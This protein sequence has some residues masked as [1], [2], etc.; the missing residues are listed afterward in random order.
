MSVLE[1]NKKYLA[2]R[3]KTAQA[4]YKK[5]LHEDCVNYIEFTAA[6]AWLNFSGFYKLHSLEKILI[7]IGK[8]LEPFPNKIPKISRTEKSILHI[9]TGVKKVGGHSALLF[10]WIRLDS[11]NKHTLIATAQDPKDVEDVAL[12]YNEKNDAN[13]IA[14]KNQPK[15]QKAL[16]LKHYIANGDY[17][18]IIL[19]TNPN[20]AIPLLALSDENIKTPVLLLNHADHTFWLGA[21]I[22]DILIQIRESNI[23]LDKQRRN[24]DDQS[25]L[26]IPLKSPD[27]IKNY[28]EDNDKNP[29]NILSTGSLYKYTP[30][31]NY[32]F[33]KEIL[34][35]A[36]K[37]LNV[38]INIVGVDKNSAL[39]KQYQHS[40]IEYLGVLNPE[41]LNEVEN[42]MDIF[43]EGFPLPSFTALLQVA[44][45]KIPFVL[46]YDPLSSLKLFND[47]KNNGIIYPENKQ[48]WR[49]LVS[50]LI[51]DFSFRKETA[52]KQY[53][54]VEKLY[55]ENA[56]KGLLH[57]IYQKADSK[58]HRIG[59]FTS[60]HY[61]HTEN[62]MM[63]S[64][65]DSFMI[66]HFKHTENLGFLQKIKLLSQ[67]YPKNKNVKYALSNTQIFNYIFENR[68]Y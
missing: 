25:V 21:A 64:K 47:N 3:I 27:F 30:N 66:S 58:Q 16:E 15:L 40:R 49:D 6:F 45:K 50:N 34:A 35:I 56:W 37:H 17:D 41:E 52:E 10:N 8:T 65:I 54:L 46:H 59:N 57:Q 29:V 62:E 2:K 22:T 1:N 51:E 12:S 7:A 36:E 5:G 31:E 24:I 38:K 33:Y 23:S 32:N 44:Q 55:S 13:L 43:I 60:D 9:C 53:D 28:D 68:L 20:D 67:V 14:L 39:A 48:E 63:L 26:P 19:H 42:R 4:L 18:Y 11:V 61:Y